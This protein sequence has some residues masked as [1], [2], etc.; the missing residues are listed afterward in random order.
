MKSRWQEL[1]DQ[2]RDR[3]LRT[4]VKTALRISRRTRVKDPEVARQ[5]AERAK[6][7]ELFLQRSERDRRKP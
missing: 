2:E 4:F 3:L 5:L 6:Q 7:L 1:T